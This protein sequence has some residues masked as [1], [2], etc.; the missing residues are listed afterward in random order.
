[1]PFVPA[2]R[3]QAEIVAAGLEIEGWL[4]RTLVE[5]TLRQ[6]YNEEGFLKAEIAGRPLTI[7]GTV[8]V[9]LVDIKEGPRAQITTRLFAGVA[10]TQLP[11]VEK[12]AALTLPAPYVAAEVNEARVRI[13]EHYRRQGF[14]DA[15][16]EVEPAVAPDDTVTLTFHVTEGPQQVLRAVELTGNEVTSDKVLTQ[17]LRFK[18]GQPADL[19]EWALARKRLYDTNVFRLVE[20]QTVPLGEAADGVQPVK[21]VVKVEEYPAW[22]FR[23]GFQL[24]GERQAELEQFTSSRNAGV[25]SELRTPNLFGR[26]LNSGV[27]GMYQRDRQDAS[28]FV[29]SSRLFGWSARSTLYS[30]FS[31]DR[32]RNDTGE[33]SSITDQQG[34]SA[35]QR[36][37]PKGFQVI[38]GYRFE[39]NHTVIPTSLDDPLP[40]FDIVADVAKLSSAVLF[41]RR[42]DPINARKGTF[43]SIS[44]DYASTRLGSDVSN[45]KVLAQQFVFVPIRRLVLASRVLAGYAFGRDPLQFADRFRAGGATSVRGYGEDGL[46]PR[47]ENGFESGGDRLV[48][49]NQELRFPIYWWFNGVVFADAGNVFTTEQTTSFRDLK[50]GVGFGLRLDTPVG[51]IRGDVGFPQSTLGAGRTTKTR[52][53]FGFGHIF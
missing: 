14:N 39:R 27:F 34:I 11:Q 44:F 52:Y 47:D 45:R 32:V 43:S 18:I 16:V 5:R 53:Y 51:L 12:A 3:L 9:L 25:V 19:D 42:D 7:E 31:R 28:V 4:D 29:A 24:E 40:S 2:D 8:G 41:D 37:R 13:E 30:F 6:V 33:I 23:Y 17:A 26:A 50:V 15:E 20:I 35:D 38:Y 22:S 21:A 1:M 10:E 46:N 49:L 48:I 36:W